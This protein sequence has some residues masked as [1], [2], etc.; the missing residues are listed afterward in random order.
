MKN[1]SAA[2]VKC[3]RIEAREAVHDAMRGQNHQTVGIHVDEGHH[4]RRFGNAGCGNSL[5][6]C[7]GLAD[8][9]RRVFLGVIERGLVAVVAVGN[10]EL[11]VGHGGGQQADG[12]RI[13]RRAKGG[14]A[15]R[16]RR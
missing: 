3:G 13:A 8:R 4:H 1:S 16:I 12:R 14:A 15:R 7:S 6:L 9:A 11:L 10:D 2:R 5:V